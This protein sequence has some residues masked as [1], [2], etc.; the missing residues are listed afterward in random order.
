VEDDPPAIQAAPADAHGTS[1][2]GA[3][4]VVALAG[5][6]VGAGVMVGWLALKPRPATSVPDSGAD[7][8]LYVDSDV[9]ARIGRSAARKLVSLG[10]PRAS[11]KR[12]LVVLGRDPEVHLAAQTTTVIFGFLLPWLLQ[13]AFALGHHHLSVPFTGT[14]SLMLAGLFFYALDLEVMSKAAEARSD[15]LADL[16]VFL[17]ITVVS[18][19]AGTGVEQ[20]LGGASEIGESPAFDRLRHSL[21]V[22]FLSRIP[23]HEA[24]AELG[25]TLGLPE[26]QELAASLALAGTEGAKIRASLAAKAESIRATT[27]ADEEAAAA[28]ATER[29]TIPISLLMA[30]FL[31]LLMFPAMATAL[32][33]L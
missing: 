4:M 19:A 3:D 22:A 16:S 1:T 31:V 15:A 12:D 5:A 25:A 17:D 24:F 10:L 33:A 30:G 8:S 11:I 29:M 23:I 6:M 13:T 7:D 14:V 18:L 32:T 2:G 26:L 28:S 9:A 21:D 27:L 20:S